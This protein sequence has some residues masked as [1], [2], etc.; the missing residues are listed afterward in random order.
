MSAGTHRE[1]PLLHILRKERVAAPRAP[2]PIVNAI[3]PATGKRAI[4]L[5]PR[6]SK[7]DHSGTT[8]ATSR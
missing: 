3:R 1:L 8:R 6:A 4:S 5:A 2:V 7:I